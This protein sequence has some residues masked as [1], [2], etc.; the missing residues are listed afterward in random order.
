MKLHLFPKEERPCSSSGESHNTVVQLRPGLGIQLQRGT[1]LSLATA[2]PGKCW[3]WIAV[4]HFIYNLDRLYVKSI[5]Y[6]IMIK[7]KINLN[8]HKNVSLLDR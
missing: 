8:D 5:L 4:V 1:L 6:M 2:L 3:F 7:I